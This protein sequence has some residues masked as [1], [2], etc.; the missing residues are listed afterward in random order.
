MTMKDNETAYNYSHTDNSL[1][2]CSLIAFSENIKAIMCFGANPSNNN[3]Q[4][5]GVTLT[6][7]T[8]LE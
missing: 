3:K 5:Y 2:V 4:N 6:L 8:C 1:V 7:I